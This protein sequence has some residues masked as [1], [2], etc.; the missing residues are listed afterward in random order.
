LGFEYAIGQEATSIISMD[1]DG[2]HPVEFLTK[3]INLVE[4]NK[5]E[6]VIA[7][8]KFL[9]W[10]SEKIFA[11]ITNFK[12]SIK[13]ITC[14][15]KC[16]RASLFKKYG[17]KDNYNSIGTFLSLNALKNKHKFLTI[18]IPL[19]RRKGSST[20]GNSLSAE[21]KILW[22]IIKSIPLLL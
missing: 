4:N 2:Q 10:K 13:D 21:L 3:M 7:T 22:A 20:F 14:G 15:M 18:E 11:Q 5:Y 6:I 16:Y 17:F 9:P 1:A 19:K 12:Y 8:R